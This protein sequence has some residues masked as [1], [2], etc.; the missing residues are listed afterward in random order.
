VSLEI[1]VAIVVLVAIVAAVAWWA[2]QRRRTDRLRE[3][4]GPEYERTVDVTDDRRR[5]ESE[6]EA[7]QERVDALEIRPLTGPN[8]ARFGERWR[9]IQALFVDDPTMAV[10]QADTLI[11][12]VMRARGYPVGDF[13]QRAADISVNHPQVVDHYRTAH[14][15][16]ERR[17][18]GTIDTEELRQAFVHYRA[19]FAD[20]LD[21][22]V[23]REAARAPQGVMATPDTAKPTWR[24]EEPVNEPAATAVEAVG[25][26]DPVEPPEAVDPAAGA[27]SAEA[28]EP[29]EPARRP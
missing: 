4:F 15:I 12:E 16:A 14:R 29:V 20:L 6:L 25:P 10:D 2:G 11:G 8:R 28:A 23:S 3:R 24:V 9:V 26:A 18:A 22:G 21:T 17:I 13:E 1:I 27:E 7:R 5:A 19:L